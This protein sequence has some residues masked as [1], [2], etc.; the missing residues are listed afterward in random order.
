MRPAAPARLSSG[1]LCHTDQLPPVIISPHL[2]SE[3]TVTVLTLLQSASNSSATMRARAVPTCWPISARIMLTVTA[4][5][6]SIP[7]Q[8]VGSNKSLALPVGPPTRARPE[9]AYPSMTPAPA[10]AIRKPRRETSV[11]PEPLSPWA[12]KLIMLRSLHPRRCKLDGF[13]DSNVSHAAADIPAHDGA[14]VLVTGVGIIF[15][16][17]GSLHD[18]S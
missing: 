14:D 17:R 18:L 7:Y 15:Q 9:R 12:D 5:L 6:G 3:S 11:G 10:I 16:Q 13:A 4:P 1:K 8:I 2:G